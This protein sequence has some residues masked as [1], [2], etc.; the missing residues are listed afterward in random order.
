MQT[1]QQGTRAR[2][3]RCRSQH[4]IEAGKGGSII[5][6]ISGTAIRLRSVDSSIIGFNVKTADI[7]AAQLGLAAGQTATLT[8]ISSFSIGAVA[9]STL[10]LRRLTRT[11]LRSI[12]GTEAPI[13][14]SLDAPTAVSTIDDVI[15]RIE[16]ATNGNVSVFVNSAGTAWISW[17]FPCRAWE[18]PR[19]LPLFRGIPMASVYTLIMPA[20]RQRCR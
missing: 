3:P 14:V 7:S 15:T 8:V 2:G 5:A 17:I 19:H 13:R 11:I 12:S 6:E 10:E 4:R 20:Q 18:G 16:S 9:V 1:A